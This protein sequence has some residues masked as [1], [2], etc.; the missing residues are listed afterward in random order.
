MARVIRLGKSDNAIAIR[1]AGDEFIILA[2]KS[3]EDSIK[4]MIRNI[5]DEVDLFNENEDR[6][7]KLSLSI[8]YT[9]YDYDKD[10]IDSFFKHMDDNMYEEKAK[11]HSDR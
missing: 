2:A 9:I 11:K 1:F 5:R 7:Y 8:G 10:D 3:T 6:Q 4:K